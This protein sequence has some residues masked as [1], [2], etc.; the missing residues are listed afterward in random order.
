MGIKSGVPQPMTMIS[1]AGERGARSEGG[2]ARESMR[3]YSWQ[4]CRGLRSVE[5]HRG[6][7]GV[8]KREIEGAQRVRREYLHTPQKKCRMNTT[9]TLRFPPSESLPYR[10]LKVCFFLSL[11]N[12][13]TSP[14]CSRSAF[15][16]G[17]S[18]TLMSPLNSPVGPS[19]FVAVCFTAMG[20]AVVL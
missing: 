3:R 8:Y 4:F 7:E 15:D 2:M 14:A 19:G 9:S 11:S 17:S 13:S 5:D 10:L 20:L 16:G 18:L 12:T 6:D 1:V